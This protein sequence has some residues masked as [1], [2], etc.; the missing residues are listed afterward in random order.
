RLVDDMTLSEQDE[1]AS[2]IAGAFDDAG[3]DGRRARPSYGYRAKH[4]IVRIEGCPVEI[5]VRT[6]LQDLWAQAMES[7][8][9][10]WGRQIRYGLPPD[11]DQMP[12]IE[13]EQSP[14]TRADVVD[15][16]AGFSVEIA[17]LEANGGAS[18]E[19]AT[20]RTQLEGLARAFRTLNLK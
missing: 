13:D 2:R 4:V 17:R 15:M 10:A 12:L 19:L 6:R 11:E 8:G 14:V 16:M 3:I 18:E 20:L 9:D 1:L 7:L 5:Q